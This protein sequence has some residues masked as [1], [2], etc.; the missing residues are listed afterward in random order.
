VQRKIEPRELAI[1]CG[2]SIVVPLTLRR[3][4]EREASLP[5]IRRTIC[6]ILFI[7]FLLFSFVTY[8]RQLSRPDRSLSFSPGDSHVWQAGATRACSEFFEYPSPLP[9]S[10]PIA[11]VEPRL[12]NRPD[13]WRCFQYGLLSGCENEARE[14]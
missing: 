7:G 13:V 5:L 6:H 10:L 4:T 8:C 3:L 2:L 12:S 11:L 9:D 14:D 1:S